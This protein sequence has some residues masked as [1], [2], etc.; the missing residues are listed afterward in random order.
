MRVAILGVHTSCGQSAAAPAPASGPAGKRGAVSPPAL[1]PRRT[2]VARAG[3]RRQLVGAAGE[4]LMGGMGGGLGKPPNDGGGGGG[5][6]NEGGPVPDLAQVRRAGRNAEL[7][8]VVGGLGGGPICGAA[9]VGLAILSPGKAGLLV[10][11]RRLPA[12]AAPASPPPCPAADL[13]EGLRVPQQ[14]AAPA[15]RG[16]AAGQR[17]VLP[18]QLEVP[19]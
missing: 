2:V 1:R 3:G 13:A 8:V 5:G 11:P 6:G 4:V 12:A 9:P 16:G 10:T 7:W 15:V 17:G 19:N 18:G 14:A